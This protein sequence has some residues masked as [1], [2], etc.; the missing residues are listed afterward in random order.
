MLLYSSDSVYKQ[1]YERLVRELQVTKKQM[2]QQ[3]EEEIEQEL[4]S[5][6]LIERKV[7]HSNSFVFTG[8]LGVLQTKPMYSAFRNSHPF[9]NRYYGRLVVYFYKISKA[10]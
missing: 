5:R 4:Q 1:R 2:Q 6:K 10:G 3:H 7:S 8:K 9:L